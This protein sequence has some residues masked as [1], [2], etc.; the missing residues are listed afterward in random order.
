MSLS[1]YVMYWSV[2]GGQL[3]L[4]SDNTA[5]GDHKE[6]SVDLSGWTWRDAGTA[7]SVLCQFYR[8]VSFRGDSSDEDNHNLHIQIMQIRLRKMRGPSSTAVL[9]AAEIGSSYNFKIDHEYLFLS[10]RSL[11]KLLNLKD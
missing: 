9:N 8:E 1:S 10:A 3:N 5:G 7:W 6:A 11:L 2:D 4:M